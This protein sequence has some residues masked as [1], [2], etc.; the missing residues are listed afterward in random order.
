M[1]ANAAI[2]RV[3]YDLPLNSKGRN[4]ARLAHDLIKTIPITSVCFSPIGRA[5]ETKDILVSS[6]N[7]EEYESEDL[8]ECKA[9]T[10]TKMV[11]LEKDHNLSTYPEV[12]AFLGRAYRGLHSALEKDQTTLLVSHGGIH[13]ALCYYLSIEN[14]PWRI[15]NCKL[16]HFY[17]VGQLGWKAEIITKD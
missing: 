7:L 4:Q 10:W 11:E 3:D 15:G 5:V 1:N 6:L 14:H 17:P 16:V 8:S 13:F 12:K 9:N 2:K